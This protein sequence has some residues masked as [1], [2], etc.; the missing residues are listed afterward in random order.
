[1]LTHV[2]SSRRGS[3]NGGFLGFDLAGNGA[4]NNS[5]HGGRNRWS[6]SGA[7]PSHGPS[8]KSF[9]RD[10][11]QSRLNKAVHASGTNPTEDPAHITPSSGPNSTHTPSQPPSPIPDASFAAAS[12]RRVDRSLSGTGMLIG[13]PVPG[14][15]KVGGVTH[16][17]ISQR[18]FYSQPPSPIPPDTD[19]RPLLPGVLPGGAPTGT[20]RGGVPPPDG[21]TP[22]DGHFFHADQKSDEG[23]LGHTGGVTP[24]QIPL[25]KLPG[26][27]GA[28]G[29]TLHRARVSLTGTLMTVSATMGVGASRVIRTGDSAAAALAVF[30]YGADPTVSTS[31]PSARSR[32]TSQLGSLE[33]PPGGL[34]QPCPHPTADPSGN[35]A[36][37]SGSPSA[38][39]PSYDPWAAYPGPVVLDSDTDLPGGVGG[40]A[41]G[42]G[43][44][45]KPRSMSHARSAISRSRSRVRSSFAPERLKA[46]AAA[47]AAASDGSG[48]V[49]GRG[50]SLG[51]PAGGAGGGGATARGGV[52]RSNS[53]LTRH[54]RDSSKSGG[55]GG[56]CGEAECACLLCR[57]RSKVQ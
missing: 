38:L 51:G 8:N 40:G 57:T 42:G 35:T 13:S 52:P 22:E 30:N 15:L 36:S 6:V 3:L 56:V 50:T 7:V 55:R 29:P 9:N 34:A 17:Q 41:H 4:D 31:M 39:Q 46:L 54:V 23:V 16:G 10:R 24:M 19:L 33:S 21:H 28:V 45:S 43:G 1:V 53:L 12:L 25:L 18:Q 5:R 27:A 49:G 47:A 48:V 14:A 2:S 26:I 37:T 44:G 32:A 11:G 20:V